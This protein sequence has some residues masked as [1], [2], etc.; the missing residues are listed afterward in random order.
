MMAGRYVPETTYLLICLDM[1]LKLAKQCTGEYFFSFFN[2]ARE[3]TIMITECGV[4]AAG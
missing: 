2:N 1:Q 4:F 3:K